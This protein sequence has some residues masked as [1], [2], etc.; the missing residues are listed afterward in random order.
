M[1]LKYPNL[2]FEVGGHTD[3]IGAKDFNV[4]LSQE[5]ADAVRFYLN[6]VAPALHL[7]ARGYGMSRPKTDNS[8]KEGRQN[9]RRVELRVT[10]MDALGEYN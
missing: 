1:L 9:N 10:N 3:N 8:T 2:R 5:R 7:S 6:D 4:N